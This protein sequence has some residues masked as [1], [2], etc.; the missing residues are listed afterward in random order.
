MFKPLLTIAAIASLS[1]G[2]AAQD[3]ALDSEGGA[4]GKADETVDGDACGADV[5]NPRVVV[6]KRDTADKQAAWLQCGGFTDN[7]GDGEGDSYGFVANTCCSE[8][9]PSGR[10]LFDDLTATTGCPSKVAAVGAGA[11][12]RCTN[13]VEADENRGTFV[14][15]ACCAPLCDDTAARDSNGLCRGSDGRFEDDICCHPAMTTADRRGQDDDNPDRSGDFG[16]NVQTS[17]EWVEFAAPNAIG[18]NFGCMAD[19]LFAADSCC[20]A[21]CAGGELDP[22]TC[23]AAA[24]NIAGEVI[25]ELSCSDNLFDIVGIDDIEVSFC[26]DDDTGEVA[27]DLPGCSALFDSQL[28]DDVAIEGADDLQARAEALAAIDL[29]PEEVSRQLHASLEFLGFGSF[30]T[31]AEVIDFVDFGGFV[32]HRLEMQTLE[33]SIIHLTW[34]EF[35]MG[36]NEV[37]VVFEHGSSSEIVGEVSDQD[38]RACFMN[39]AE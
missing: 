9:G 11:M 15:T 31:D 10:D 4:G 14:P 34:I 7:D 30:Q 24:N 17:C 2:C 28:G 39:T 18:R 3:D 19:D 27:R 25:R 5:V 23:T 1:L 36:D 38:F 16:R 35:G 21:A 20:M 33:A 12:T 37:G 26:F 29:T 6:N 13:D 32:V 22:A 8:A